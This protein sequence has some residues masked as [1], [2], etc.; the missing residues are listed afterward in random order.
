MPTRYAQIRRWRAG[1]AIRARLHDLTG[2]LVVVTGGAS[3]IGRAAARAF[4]AQGAIVVVA[5]KDL[6]GALDTVN[7]IDNPDSA[8]GSTA[9]FGGGAHAT[10]S[11]LRMRSRYSSSRQPSGHDT[12]F[13]TCSSTT[14]GSV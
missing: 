6:D 2:T 5:D 4:A 13:P 3:G 12:E 1:T 9:V 14:Q 7:L 10:N 8:G 11:M